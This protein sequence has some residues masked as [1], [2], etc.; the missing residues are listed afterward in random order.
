MKTLR[1]ENIEGILRQINDLDELEWRLFGKAV[2]HRDDE[3]RMLVGNLK[4]RHTEIFSAVS[5]LKGEAEA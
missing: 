5:Q 3:L 2:E 1:D 4:A